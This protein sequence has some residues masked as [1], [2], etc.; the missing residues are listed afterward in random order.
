MAPTGESESIEAERVLRR[1]RPSPTRNQRSST[2][3][4]DWASDMLGTWWQWRAGTSSSPTVT[5]SSPTNVVRPAETEVP[6]LE[7]LAAHLDQL[8][9]AG[10]LLGAEVPRLPVVLVQLDPE[11]PATLGFVG[12]R[13]RQAWSLAVVAGQE[14]ER[15]RTLAAVDVH[16]LRRPAVCPSI[17]V[18]NPFQSHAKDKS[19]SPFVADAFES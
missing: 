12:D 10:T 15:L 18:C 3:R 13:R 16:A 17:L 9:A 1:G 14:R 4:P 11:A 5:V 2:W 8:E 7:G 6:G 19:T